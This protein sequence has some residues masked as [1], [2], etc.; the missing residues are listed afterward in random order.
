[1]KGCSPEGEVTLGTDSTRQ[2]LGITWPK[3]QALE[4]VLCGHRTPP[5]PKTTEPPS[6][7][8]P[9]FRSQAKVSWV[10]QAEQV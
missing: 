2:Q 7:M 1:M 3:D 9:F 6:L 5:T 8:A 10:G 4:L